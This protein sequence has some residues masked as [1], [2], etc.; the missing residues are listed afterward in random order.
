MSTDPVIVMPFRIA[1]D[2]VAVVVTLPTMWWPAE[3]G[4]SSIVELGRMTVVTDPT[5]A[6]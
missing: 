6:W 4:V 1:D 5:I 2:G 3:A